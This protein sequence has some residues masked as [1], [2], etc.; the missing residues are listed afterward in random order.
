MSD[1]LPSFFP[2]YNSPFCLG[3]LIVGVLL[4]SSRTLKLYGC[5]GFQ[6]LSWKEKLESNGHGIYQG[7]I[8]TEG[9]EKRKQDKTE[10]ETGL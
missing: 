2:T 3:F 1:A 4:H 5:G 10:R 8:P 9:R 6:E 7:S